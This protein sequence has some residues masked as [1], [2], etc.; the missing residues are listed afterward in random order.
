LL[1]LYRRELMEERRQDAALREV[2]AGAAATAQ[3]MQAKNELER[4][5]QRRVERLRQEQAEALAEKELLQE[6]AEKVRI[7]IPPA[8]C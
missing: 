7:R 5:S 2:T 6:M 3:K 1:I 8:V 4:M